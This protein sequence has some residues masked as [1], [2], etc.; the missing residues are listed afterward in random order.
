MDNVEL[1]EFY[2]TTFNTVS[3]GYGHSAMRFFSK[4]AEQI[5]SY[6]NLDGDEHILDV[7]TGTGYAAFKI[8]KA[9][10]D[11]HV[12][13]ID[14]S[15]GMLAQAEKNKQAQGIH[16]VTFAEMD[17]EVIDFQD[18]Y[19]DGAVS[20]FSIFFVDDMK[21]QLV[22]IA[23]KVKAGGTILTTTFFENAFSPLVNLFFDRLEK[24]G[25]ETPSLA[26]RRVATQEQCATLFKEAG[27]KDIECGQKQCGH[28]LKDASEWWYIICNGGFRGLVNQLPQNDFGKFKADHL[29]EVDILASD[30]GIWLEIS[31]LYTTGSK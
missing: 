7:A 14:F 9:L 26:W 6:L 11:G 27:L 25:I 17:M 8:A 12:T 30:K 23:E 10:P 18:N 21:R 31:V 22:H 13:G 5:S 24:Y 28:Y 19:F 2:K 16:N 3:H 15:E 4:S 20:S 1:K 29:S